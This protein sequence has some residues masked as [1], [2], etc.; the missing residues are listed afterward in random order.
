MQLLH[1]AYKCTNI[2]ISKIGQCAYSMP[3]I[4]KTSSKTRLDTSSTTLFFFFCI[5][6]SSLVVCCERSRNECATIPMLKLLFMFFWCFF[7]LSPLFL[8]T[9]ILL[10]LNIYNL[11]IRFIYQN[12]SFWLKFQVWGNPQYLYQIRVTIA[13]PCIW[14]IAY[15]CLTCLKE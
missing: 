6:F 12:H 11:I 5:D 4:T 15:V 14:V 7:V 10:D 8:L 9:N 1:L 3:N 13:L 2:T